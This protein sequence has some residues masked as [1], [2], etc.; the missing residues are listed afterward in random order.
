MIMIMLLHNTSNV[1]MISTISRVVVCVLFGFAL[2]HHGVHAAPTPE[3][4]PVSQYSKELCEEKRIDFG[5]DLYELF[6][7]TGHK[8]YDFVYELLYTLCW[9]QQNIGGSKALNTLVARLY[10][11]DGDDI[12]TH[13]EPRP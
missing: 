12:L 9:D 10:D 8:D 11:K 1:T 7:P 13:W 6:R 4:L 3:R 5:K 2:G